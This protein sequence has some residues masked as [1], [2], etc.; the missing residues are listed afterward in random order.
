MGARQQWQHAGRSEEYSIQVT[1][2]Q[3]RA[4]LNDNGAAN[5][6]LPTSRRLEQHQVGIDC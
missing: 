6:G 4:M 3:R 5:N 1:P 2:N